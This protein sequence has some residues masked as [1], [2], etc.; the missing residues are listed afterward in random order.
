MSREPKKMMLHWSNT[1][2]YVAIFLCNVKLCNV[3]VIT[4]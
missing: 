2:V 1:D 4:D 3:I